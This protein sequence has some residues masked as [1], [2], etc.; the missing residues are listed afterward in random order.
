MTDAQSFQIDDPNYNV[1]KLKL[2]D[3]EL[4]QNFSTGAPITR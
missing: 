2:E 4:L 3:S 1:G